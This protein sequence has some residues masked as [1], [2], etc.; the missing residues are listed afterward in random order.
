MARHG[1]DTPDL[2]ALAGE[3]WFFSDQQ[4][5]G[6]DTDRELLDPSLNAWLDMIYDPAQELFFWVVGLSMSSCDESFCYEE[7]DLEG[8]ARFIV[9]YNTTPDVY[10]QCLGVVYEQLH[11]ASFPL[12]IR[13]SENVEPIDEHEDM[14]FPLETLLTHWIFL[15]RLGKVVAGLLKGGSQHRTQEGL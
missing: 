3:K 14:W 5:P 7:N 13:S 4:N 15:I 10:S 8:K 2:T 9:I 6:R 1:R 12:T 11:R